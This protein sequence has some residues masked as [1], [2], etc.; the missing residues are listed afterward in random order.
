MACPPVILSAVKDLDL[1]DVITTHRLIILLRPLDSSLHY[2]SLRMT[3]WG[4]SLK[5]VLEP[6]TA[7]KDRLCEGMTF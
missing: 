6:F 7:F 5:F 4:I 3:I 2:V 1:V